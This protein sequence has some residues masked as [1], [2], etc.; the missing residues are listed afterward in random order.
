MISFTFGYRYD[1]NTLYGKTFNPRI[2]AWSSSLTENFT[3]KLLYGT[4]FRA[5]SGWELFSATSAR[6]ENINLTPERMKSHEIGLGYRAF[7]NIIF[8]KWF[9]NQ[10]KDIIL[11]VRTDDSSLD[12]V[13]KL[14]PAGKFWNQ[15]QNAGDA[16]IYGIEFTSNIPLHASLNFNLNTAHTKKVSSIIFPVN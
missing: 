13:T 15:N 12:P 14:P 8:I 4:G 1:E 5:P 6:K 7:K 11:E 9:Y 10:V 3:I 16:R 2:S